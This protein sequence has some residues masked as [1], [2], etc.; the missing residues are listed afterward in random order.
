MVNDGYAVQGQRRN[1]AGSIANNPISLINKEFSSTECSRLLQKVDEL[2]EILQEEKYIL[3][4]IIVVGE[5]S[6]SR[7]IRLYYL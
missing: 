5:Q 7:K 6:V 4:H 2:R 1:Q 3:P